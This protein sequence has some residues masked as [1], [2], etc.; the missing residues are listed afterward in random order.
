LEFVSSEKREYQSN[1]LTELR[2]ITE[3]HAIT[4]NVVFFYKSNWQNE[5]L[6]LQRRNKFICAM[7]VSMQELGIEGPRMR[8]PGQKESFPVYLQNVPYQ[9]SHSMTDNQSPPNRSSGEMDP[10][11][12]EPS[13]GRSGGGLDHNHNNTINRTRPRGESLAQMGKR[14]DFSLG[15]RDVVSSNLAG[16]IFSPDDRDRSRTLAARLPS[17]SSQQQ[18]NSSSADRGRTSAAADI[19]R[20]RSGS[21][22]SQRDHAAALGS[23]LTR[24]GTDS[25]LARQRSNHRNRFF[26]RYRAS[27]EIEESGMEEGMAGIPEM[28]RANSRV[29]PRSG[30]VS[31]TAW[32]TSAE[33]P[34]GRGSGGVLFPNR[35]YTTH[36]G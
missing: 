11:F 18:R 25:S 15:M 20:N 8:Y 36:S 29:D 21:M 23:Q 22:L 35:S 33:E 12:V 19:G 5:L 7:M 26:S 4:L 14:V 10:P 9:Q 6:R 31:P 16:D 1:I 3:A 13:Q 27:N 28:S 34:R 24:I 2:D 32:R 17:P 30:R